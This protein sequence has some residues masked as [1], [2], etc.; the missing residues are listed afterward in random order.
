MTRWLYSA[1]QTER[2]SK[3][4]PG[5]R[6]MTAFGQFMVVAENN[7]KTLPYSAMVDL[8]IERAD[9]IH[10]RVGKAHSPQV[11]DRPTVAGLEWTELFE[12]WWDQ[13]VE[14]R[15]AEGRPLLNDQS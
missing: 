3:A 8:A 15:R 11:R 9:H 1:W 12:S 6:I 4:L 14:A 13:N 7:L 5:L 10:A 2:I